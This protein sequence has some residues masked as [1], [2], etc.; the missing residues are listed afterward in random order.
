[1]DVQCD[2]RWRTHC[3][4]PPSEHDSEEKCSR[5][6]QHDRRVEEDSRHY[7]SIIHHLS[8]SVSCR[9]L[10]LIERMPIHSK[11][12]LLALSSERDRDHDC[13][14]LMRQGIAFSFL[15]FNSFAHVRQFLA[16]KKHVVYRMSLLQ[17]GQ[18]LGL[19]S[20]QITNRHILVDLFLGYIFR[21]EFLTLDA[22]A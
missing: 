20:T 10:Q 1:M 5:P 17:H 6:Q 7:H 2:Q 11:D 12:L 21:L 14:G 18:I 15:L 4:R 22:Q 13:L 19:F 16:H 8:E 9:L 3:T